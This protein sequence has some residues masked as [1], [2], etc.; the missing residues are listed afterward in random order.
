[1]K[2]RNRQTATAKPT[3]CESEIALWREYGLEIGRAISGRREDAY[4]GT[5]RSEAPRGVKPT[6]NEEAA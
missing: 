1:M 4:E 5:G 6:A 3:S 2:T